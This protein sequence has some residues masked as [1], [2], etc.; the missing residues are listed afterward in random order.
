MN[1]KE[2]LIKLICSVACESDLEGQLGSC[3]DRKFAKCRKV[4]QLDHCAVQ[5]IVDHLIENGVTIH[6]NDPLAIE[7]LQQMYGEPVWVKKLDSDKSFWMLAYKDQV[8]N[9]I[10]WLDYR[11]YGKDWVAYRHKPEEV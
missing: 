3:P 8:C 1:I 5:H 11:G 4:E 7:E 10:G 9:R 2:K 6:G